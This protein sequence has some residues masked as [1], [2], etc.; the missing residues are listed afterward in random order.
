MKK[1]QYNSGQSHL[2]R[3]QRS[4]GGQVGI[5]MLL[6]TVVMLTVGISAISRTTSDV[7]ISTTN[8]QANRALDA[9]ES[10]V[11]RAL[12]TDL[13]TAPSSTSAPSTDANVTVRTDVA[14]KN[15]LDTSV[16]QGYSVAVDVNGLANNTPVTIQWAKEATCSQASLV[17]TVLS[18]NAADPVRRTYIGAPVNAACVKNDGFSIAANN[19]VAT[20]KLSTIIST[21]TN[22]KLI[23]I[24]PLYF[25]TDIRVTST[26]AL[27][28][29]SYTVTSTAQNINSKETKAVQVE[30][31]LPVAPAVLDYVLF[32]GTSITQ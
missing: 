18:T 12:S 28:T 20:Y 26:V 7:S 1:T 16:D 24:R 2:Q 32:S 9:A 31:T 4:N 5:I 8:E 25:G 10:G 3:L 19:P 6:I 22:D 13:S 27:P 14:Q 30:R 23:R 29:Q 15:S 21:R 17:I 11:E